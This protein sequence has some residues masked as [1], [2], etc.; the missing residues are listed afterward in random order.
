MKRKSLHVRITEAA[1]TLFEI[2]FSAALAEDLPR[3]LP[4]RARRMLAKRQVNVA[5][6]TAGAR[7]RGFAPGELFRCEEGPHILRAWI[8]HSD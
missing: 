7:A 8:E 3:L 4:N 5:E 6:I 2:S 1:E